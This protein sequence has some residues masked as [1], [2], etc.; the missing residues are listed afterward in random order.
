MI[1]TLLKKGLIAKFPVKKC[2]TLRT[3]QPIREVTVT[4]KHCECQSNCQNI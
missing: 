4:I 3:V 1:S 2:T